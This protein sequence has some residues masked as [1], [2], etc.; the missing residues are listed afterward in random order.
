MKYTTHYLGVEKVV[1]EF[2]EADVE[3]ALKRW[4]DEMFGKHDYSKGTWEF[5]WEDQGDIDRYESKLIFYL[6]HRFEKEVKPPEESNKR[7]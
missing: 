4:M 6:T 5:H 2:D 3:K 7:Q 1:Y